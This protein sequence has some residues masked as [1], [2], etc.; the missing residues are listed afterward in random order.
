MRR[1]WI[2]LWVVLIA[3][4]ASVPREQTGAGGPLGV[5]GVEPTHLTAEYW[6]R[7]APRANAVLL[8]TSAIAQQNE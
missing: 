3:G 8:D 4:C 5:I 2:F 1:Y 7:R 6:A